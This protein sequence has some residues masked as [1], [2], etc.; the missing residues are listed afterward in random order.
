MGQYYLLE[1]IAQGGMAEIY[2]GLAY[3]LHGIKRTVVIKKILPQAA[4]NKEFIDMLV[5]E[6][7]IAV[8]LS[9][10]NIAQ[11]YDLGKA[12]ENYFIVMEYVEGRSVS[13]LMKQ[14]AATDQRIPLPLACYLITEIAAGLDYMHRRADE[15]GHPLHIIHRDVSPQNVIVSYSGTVKIIDFGIA[16]ARTKL[17]TTDIGILKGKF[18]YMS[19]EQAEGNPV[20][21][22]SDLFSLGVILYEMLTGQRLFKAKENRETLRNVRKAVVPIPSSVRPDLPPELDQIVARALAKHREDRYPFASLLRDDLLRFLHTHFPDFRSSGLADFVASVFRNEPAPTIG[23]EEAKTPLL[24]I[25]HTQ[26]A[27]AHPTLGEATQM[28]AEPTGVPAIMTEYLLTM[29]EPQ[30]AGRTTQDAGREE[31]SEYTP[32]VRVAPMSRTTR[33]QRPAMIGVIVALLCATAAWWTWRHVHAPVS[34]WLSRPAPSPTDQRVPTAP[35]PAPVGSV[36][37]TTSPPG[38]QIFL[39][40]QATPYR[41]PTTIDR[42]EAGRTYSIGA[43]LEHY[44]FATVSWTARAGVAD[45]LSLSLQID[46][47]AL[48]ILS[49]PEGARVTLDGTV[50]GRTPVT[51]TQLMPGTTLAVE[52]TAPGYQSWR[53]AVRIEPGKTV[54]IRAELHRT[55]GELPDAANNASGKELP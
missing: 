34:A 47:G 35:S 41:T 4:A 18:A 28:T 26:S 27:L 45:A 7:K 29:E 32:I 55:R 9:H 37:I 44:I 46:Y 31:V 5:A 23:E 12:G 2:K 49:V 11:I 17:E 1:K 54:S 24:I 43:F 21:H 25:D 52:V 19:P 20:D 50:V 8:I 14:C 15:H 10:G 13:Q 3:D 33:W 39:D 36:T 51:R 38:A 53:R 48:D 30:D 40:D 6:A 22:R 42:L 16:K